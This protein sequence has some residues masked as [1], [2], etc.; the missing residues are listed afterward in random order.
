MIRIYDQVRARPTYLV[1]RTV[2]LDLDS[3][4]AG[5]PDRFAGRRSAEGPR[6]DVRGIDVGVLR[7]VGESVATRDPIA[8]QAPPL[9]GGL[10]VLTPDP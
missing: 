4:V 1:D 8:G 6:P 5:R 7:D 2:N 9:H 10:T 3:D